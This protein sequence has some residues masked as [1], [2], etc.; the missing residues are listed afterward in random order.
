MPEP[1]QKAPNTVRESRPTH[2]GFFQKLRFDSEL[3]LAYLSSLREGL[4]YRSLIAF[5]LGGG[6][7]MFLMAV[8]VYHLRLLSHIAD[9]TLPAWQLLIARI[10]VLLGLLLCC[11]AFS[12]PSV[13]YRQEV[14][15]ATQTY[16]L[17][18]GGLVVIYC[19][20]RLH[21]PYDSSTLILIVLTMFLPL[22]LR[23]TARL[24]L[25]LFFV[26]TVLF[27]ALLVVSE[28][29]RRPM[30]QLTQLLFMSTAVAAMGAY[31][32]E[33]SDRQQFL[34]RRELEWHADHDSLTGLHNRRIFSR[35][36]EACIGQAHR[37]GRSLALVLMDVDHFK[38]YNDAYGHQA[39]DQ[40]LKALA[41]LLKDLAA[42]P[43]D[44]AAR[45]GGEEMALIFF[46]VEAGQAQALCERLV[47]GVRALGIP[48]TSSPT[49]SCM[50]VSAGCAM[51][52]DERSE[53]ALYQR[54]DKLLYQ[55]KHGGR[56]GFLLGPP[57]QAAPADPGQG[58][59]A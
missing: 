23:F 8:D 21:L 49:A 3:E 43:L 5:L 53:D 24:V 59:V 56:N 9:L 35:H 28:E 57:P 45:V 17:A 29:F 7:W 34:L 30:L 16:L 40:A 1:A 25:A 55:V 58:V 19:Y 44:L 42:R 47:R 41:E 15:V 22:G 20:Q 51:L 52:G 18:L 39:G 14:L 4:R 11:V 38:L 12:R 36:L 6:V 48:H 10:S 33:H 37:D 27:F 2:W 46:D 13:R 32:L 50:T 31:L 26:L 54:A